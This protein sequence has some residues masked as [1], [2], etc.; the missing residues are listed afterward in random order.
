MAF[1]TTL[2]TYL[3]KMI[4]YVILAV[5]GIFAGKSLR[6]RKDAKMALEQS[7]AKTKE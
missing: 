3:G 2:L 7:D 5:L 4:I 6:K 1:L